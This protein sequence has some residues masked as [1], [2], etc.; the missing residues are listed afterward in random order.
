MELDGCGGGRG[1]VGGGGHGRGSSGESSV[2]G[3]GSGNGGGVMEVVMGLV[4]VEVAVKVWWRR[5]K[6]CRW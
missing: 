4:T 2:G 6:W 1:G 5:W 3:G